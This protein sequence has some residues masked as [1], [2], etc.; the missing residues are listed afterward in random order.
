MICDKPIYAKGEGPKAL[1]AKA[2]QPKKVEWD[3]RRQ[4]RRDNT[5]ELQEARYQQMREKHELRN[6][7]REKTRLA[8]CPGCDVKNFYCPHAEHIECV[9]DGD[10]E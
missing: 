9:S 4:Q 7:Q 10:D 6:A 8:T 2:K 3:E 1:S 5:L